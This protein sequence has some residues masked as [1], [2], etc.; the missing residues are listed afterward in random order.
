MM[1][2]K[3]LVIA[4]AFLFVLAMF[5]TP[6]MARS[7][8]VT[9]EGKIVCAKCVLHAEG[10]EGCQNV[11]VVDNGKGKEKHYFLTRNDVY[12]KQGDVCM[13]KPQVR[14][15]GTV[16]KQDGQRWLTA[17]EMLPVDDAG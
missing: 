1:V 4:S 17:S 2:K 9:L 11:L 3:S 7:K 15:T 16:S 5:A 6:S 8:T 13:A 12:E 10:Q 14:V